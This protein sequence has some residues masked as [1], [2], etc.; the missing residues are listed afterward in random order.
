MDLVGA[1]ALKQGIISCF[2]T[3]ATPTMWWRFRHMIRSTIG[4][5]NATPPSPDMRTAHIAAICRPTSP[6]R[7]TIWT[8]MVIGVRYLGMDAYGI[9]EFAAPIG[10]PIGTVT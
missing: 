4:G 5:E 3:I 2:A 6:S 10:G 1:S 7:Q 9:R 8:I